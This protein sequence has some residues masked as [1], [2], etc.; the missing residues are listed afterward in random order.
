MRNSKI[1]IFVLVALLL[2]AGIVM[3]WLMVTSQPISNPY[4]FE[5]GITGQEYEGYIYPLSSKE[6]RE[7]VAL[8]IARLEEFRD[9]E[10]YALE[11]KQLDV[12]DTEDM[13]SMG[14]QYL[15]YFYVKDSQIYRLPVKDYAGFTEE[16]TQSIIKVIREDEKS[17]LDM[18]HIVC[19]EGEIDDAVDDQ[20]YHSG[21]KADGNQ[22]IYYFYNED[23]SGTKDYEKIVWEKGKGIVY[24]QRGAGNMLMHIEFGVDLEEWLRNKPENQQKQDISVSEEMCPY[25]VEQKI[26]SFSIDQGQEYQIPYVRVSGLQDAELQ[27]KINHTLWENACWI[28]DCAELTTQT[29]MEQYG[30]IR[31]INKDTNVIILTRVGKIEY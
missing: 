16:Q 17:F 22:R 23:T 2:V 31:K 11:L 6:I 8:K 9:S 7:N 1:K 4:F 3:V 30:G 14:R 27:W 29:I 20:G 26:F 13:I 19:S 10:L 24:Y 21:I 5:K 28:F 15:G 18:C 12:T 25:E